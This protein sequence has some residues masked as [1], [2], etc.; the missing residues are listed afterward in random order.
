MKYFIDTEFIEGFTRPLFGKSRH[1]IDLVSIAI[2]AEDG[3]GLY[4]IS[5]EY[6]YNRADQWVK[7]NVIKPLYLQF[8]NGDM[9][10]HFT[11]SNFHKHLGLPN[12]VIAE[13]IARFC[14]CFRDQLFWRTS[15]PIDFYGYYCDYDWVLFCSLFGKMIDLPKGF[16]MYCRDVK[17]MLD[18]KLVQYDWF[19]NGF[20]G[21]PTSHSAALDMIK[22]HPDFPKTNKE[23]DALADAVWCKQLFK[24]LTND[25][26]NR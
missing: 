7:D 18:E 5:S 1:F 9:R 25:T 8:V 16:P 2:T 3:S 10:N 19:E 15:R 20:T 14:E 12:K 6:D 21:L 17:Q 13:R 26:K 23:H 24:F 4:L 11:V 22:N